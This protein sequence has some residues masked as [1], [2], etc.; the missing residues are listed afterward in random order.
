MRALMEG[1]CFRSTEVVHA[2]AKDSGAPIKSVVVDGGMT[3]NNTLMQTQAD[4]MNADIIRKEE[5]EITGMGAAIAAGLQVKYWNSIDDIESKIKVDR[6]FKPE[7]SDE[8][9]ADRLGRWG[10]AVE[11]SIGFGRN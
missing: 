2:M 7:I 9:R 1:P 10:Q 3:V 5:K 4:L 11:R 6:V 8:V